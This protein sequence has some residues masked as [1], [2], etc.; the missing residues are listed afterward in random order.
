MCASRSSSGW[1]SDAR[2]DQ[3]ARR[4]GRPSRRRDARAPAR[5]PR[6]GRARRRGRARVRPHRPDRR[7]QGPRVRRRTAVERQDHPLVPGGCRRG[8]A[9]RNR[10]R[11]AQLRGRRQGR[12]LA[13]G[14]RAA[15]TVPDLGAED[16]RA[17]LRRHDRLRA[18]ARTGRRARRHPAARQ[19]S[20]SIP[21]SA[22]TRSRCSGW[23]MRPSRSTSRPIAGTR[24]RSA[25]SHA[26]TLTPPARSSA[27]RHSC[28]SPSQMASSPSR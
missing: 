28:R 8:R 20:G 25:A 22:S 7:G 12:R 6:Q 2:P 11:G 27:T 14:R 18:R 9:A 10:L 1:W 16:L 24:S 19:S 26:S 21:T 3:L 4:V 17:H 23:T 5:R 15:R 13:A